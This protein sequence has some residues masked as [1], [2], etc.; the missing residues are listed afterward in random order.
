MA[1]TATSIRLVEIIDLRPI[2]IETGSRMPASEVDP[3]QKSTCE[4]CGKLHTV[5][6]CIMADGQM[7][8][9]GSGCCKKMFSWKPADDA[10]KLAT[11]AAKDKDVQIALQQAI[12][13]LT[14]LLDNTVIPA[15]KYH[16]YRWTCFGYDYIFLSEDT[17]MLTASGNPIG[18]RVA[19]NSSECKHPKDIVVSQQDLQ[20]FAKAWKRVITKRW[21][22]ENFTHWSESKVK[23][24]TVA[25][26]DLLDI[27]PEQE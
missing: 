20:K 17:S 26:Y 6:Y 19:S 11:A 21:I 18:I 12:A 27:A 8:H 15:L 4:Q 23:K 1:I 10:V 2:D 25:V 22:A 7:Y 13:P 14:E 16:S 24:F 5:I 3:E 9:V